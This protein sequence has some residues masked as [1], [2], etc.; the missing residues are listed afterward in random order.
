MASAP[1][2]WQARHHSQ[3]NLELERG[4]QGDIG[5]GHGAPS[6]G[7]RKED[8]DPSHERG[9]AGE[10]SACANE[11]DRGLDIAG[12]YLG[13]HVRFQRPGVRPPGAGGGGSLKP[14]RKRVCI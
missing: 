13:M 5:D 9:D 3:Y 8:K 4:Y 11:L 7:P 1:L 2:G 10:V 6:H 14:L 12:N